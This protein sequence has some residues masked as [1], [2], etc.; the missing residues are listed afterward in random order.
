MLQ[1]I[2]GASKQETISHLQ[3]YFRGRRSFLYLEFCG[4]GAWVSV[5]AKAVPSW[6]A[7]PGAGAAPGAGCERSAAVWAVAGQSPAEAGA[8]EPLC[9]REEGAANPDG[10]PWAGRA[11]PRCGPASG[12]NPSARPLNRGGEI[13][14]RTEYNRICIFILQQ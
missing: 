9:R 13:E 8:A 6:A 11:A 7:V 3:I 14:Y 5:S 12:G 4:A 2:R 10:R 1:S